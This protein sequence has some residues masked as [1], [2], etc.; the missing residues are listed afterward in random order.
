MSDLDGKTVLVTG[1]SK[2]IGRSLA[3]KL[4]KQGA[5]IVVHYNTSKEEALQTREE[6][7]KQGVKVHLVKADLSKPE[8][9]SRLIEE[10]L[11]KAG[12]LHGL[13]NNASVF[14][15]RGVGEAN[16]R[17]LEADM[18]IN[19]W[20]P[21][22]LSREFGRR[23]GRGKIINILDTRIAGYDF[24]NFPYYLSKKM[25]ETLTRSLALQLSPEVTVNAVAPGLIL[26]P[27]GR[28]L[29]HLERL[30]EKVP[31]KRYGSVEDVTEAVLFL[32]KS[33]FITGQIIYV[34]GGKHLVQAVEGLI[35]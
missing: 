24:D 30:K 3:V 35:P 25:L 22:L 9:S 20:A 11:T 33:N 1:A 8:S 2:R 27:V 28:G 32:L 12:G 14:K 31:L 4:A 26:P 21:F 6:V 18:M 7:A 15:R 23:V 34:D 5:N 16:I 17:E 29:D 10:A 13:I 19:A